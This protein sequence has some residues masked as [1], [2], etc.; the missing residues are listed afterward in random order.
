[1]V[2]NTT[3]QEELREGAADT[4]SAREHF[5][6]AGAAAAEELRNRAHVASELL[7]ERAG[8]AAANARVWAGDQF[9]DLQEEVEARPHRATLVAL[10]IGVF[11]GV[12][13]SAL[14]RPKPRRVRDDSRGRY[15]D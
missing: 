14:L 8:R 11:A 2:H 15:D 13:I 1:M 10:G 4:R 3:S 7:K 12:L 9:S 6:A 5:K